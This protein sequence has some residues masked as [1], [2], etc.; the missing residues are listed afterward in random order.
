MPR[1]LPLALVG[2]TALLSAC[3]SGGS[4]ASGAPSADY[5]GFCAVA[6]QMETVA[7]GPHGED[8]AAITD[9]KVMESTWTKVVATAEKMREQSPTEIKDDV[10]L[11]VS[12]L[13]DMNAVFEKNDYDLLEMAKNPGIR[14]DLEAISQR[15]GVAE[16]SERFRGFMTEN[17]SSE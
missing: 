9:P 15:S 12:S 4:D 17:C 7:S 1:R 14:E 8:P 13:V 5:A 10:T 16:A 6:V 3:G 11:M 2:L